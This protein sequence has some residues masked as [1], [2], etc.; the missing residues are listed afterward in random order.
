MATNDYSTKSCI[1][2]FTDLYEVKAVEHAI[3][4]TSA[5]AGERMHMGKAN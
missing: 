4:A 1:T 3:L 5:G 2:F